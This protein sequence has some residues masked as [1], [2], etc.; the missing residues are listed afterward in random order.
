LSLDG[1]GQCEMVVGYTDRQVKSYRWLENEETTE[2]G[3]TGALNGK[4]VVV[5]TWQLA[6]QVGGQGCN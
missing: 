2:G 3:A 4:F 6:G 1:D 5:E